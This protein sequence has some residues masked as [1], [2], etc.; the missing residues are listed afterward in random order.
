MTFEEKIAA[1][2]AVVPSGVVD[3]IRASAFAR[4]ARQHLSDHYDR[5]YG[6]GEPGL[7]NRTFEADGGDARIGAVED[8]C[9]HRAC[10]LLN[11]WLYE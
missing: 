7:M 2:A 9:W 1:L 3:M 10:C 11:D 6:N 5:A 4:D 8:R